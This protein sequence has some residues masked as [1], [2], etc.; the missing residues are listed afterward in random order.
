MK[1]PPLRTT[2]LPRTAGLVRTPWTPAIPLLAG[3]IPRTR[4]RL[5][6]FNHR[7]DGGFEALILL[8]R[9][10]PGPVSP[11]QR[12]TPLGRTTLPRVPLRMRS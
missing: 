5:Q 7:P 3:T 9:D 2:P 11:D 12:H 10:V 1:R 8:D 4:S 6:D